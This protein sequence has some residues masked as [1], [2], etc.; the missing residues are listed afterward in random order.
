MPINRNS[1]SNIPPI[2][3]TSMTT[4]AETVTGT[5]EN[6]IVAVDPDGLSAGDTID[7]DTGT[8]TLRLTAPG[9]MDLTLPASIAGVENLEGSSGDDIF[10]LTLAQLGLIRAING[11][12]GFDVV[13]FATAGAYNLS[14]LGPTIAGIE[15]FRGSQGVDTITGT[16]GDDRINGNA[17]NDTLSGGAGNDYL[18]GGAGGDTL[19]GGAGSDVYVIDAAA[20]IVDESV[21]GSDGIDEVQSYITLYLTATSIRGSVENLTLLGAASIGGRGNALNN[22]ITGNSGNNPLLGFGGNDTLI[23][24]DG[25]DSLDGGVGDDTMNGGSGDDTYYVDS[26]GDIII[27][28]AGGGSDK[29]IASINFSMVGTQLE[30]LDLWG[31]S[32]SSASTDAL[33][34]TGN[35]FDNY[36]SGNAGIN[37]LSGGA[38]NDTLDGLGG[39]DILI[40]G[41]GNDI[42]VIDASDTLVEKAGEGVD[43]VLAAFSYRLTDNFENLQLTGLR[44]VN[45]TG[46][47][48]A[49]RLT[50]NAGANTLS[51]LGGNDVLDGGAGNDVMTGGTGKDHFVFSTA[52]GGTG[53]IDRITDFKAGEDRI[54]LENAIFTALGA[55]TGL[56]SA[57]AF[58]QNVKGVALRATDRIIYE[59]DTGKLFYDADGTGAQKAVQ[60]AKLDSNLQLKASD[61]WVF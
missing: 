43:T 57:L 47:G 29:V 41:K 28:A 7:L 3:Y 8:D 60:I 36:I 16:S 34:A 25:T 26:A 58:A 18:D 9:T 46:N 1:D 51:G 55:K 42:Y 19:R 14:T 50:G 52:P 27:E 21:A 35:E 37:R 31:S 6:D 2:N 22:V 44:A 5:T 15:E 13:Q 38:G 12:A 10:I 20:D 53:N 32:G 17:G 30:K 48:A 45:A 54:D 11:M 40:G 23:G 49:N 39:A 59:T 4:V 33:D 61:F 24:G 56:L